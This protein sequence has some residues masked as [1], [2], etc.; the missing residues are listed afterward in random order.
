M[1]EQGSHLDRQE[2]LETINLVLTNKGHPPARDDATLMRAAGLRSLDFSEVAIRLEDVLG[3]ELN[4]EASTMR[5]IA[6][7]ADVV[8]FFVQASREADAHSVQ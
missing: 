6:T 7:I 8:D 3:R 4:F 1:T 2:V 5:R